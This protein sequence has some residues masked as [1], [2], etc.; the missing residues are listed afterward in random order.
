MARRAADDRALLYRGRA[1]GRHPAG[2]A[3]LGGRSG[4]VPG[5]EPSEDAISCGPAAG[6]RPAASGGAGPWP[7]SRPC[8]VIA[9]LAGAGI[10]VKR[11]RATAAQQRTANVGAAAWPRRARPWTP[12]IRSRPRS[13][14]GP[15]G[16]SSPTAQA[17]YSLLQSL[18]QPVRGVLTA[19]SG[20]V[21]ALAY[22]PDG[23][24]L[25][26][27]YSGGAIR[28]WDLA[29]HRAIS[30]TTWGAAPL[31]LAF[32]SGGKV[33]E[34]AGRRRRRHLEPGR[35]GPDH[36]AAAG[37]PGA[38][39]RG[40]VQ[41]G[42]QA[43]L[44]TGG[45]DGNVRLWNAATGQEIGPPMSSD[46]KPV[47]GRGVQPQR[48]AGGRGQRG[49]KRPAVEHGQP[50]GGRTGPGPATARRL[51]RWRSAPTASCWPPAARTAPP[52]SGT[53]RRGA[54]SARPWRPATR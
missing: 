51:T 36:R 54:R 47:D 27:G 13:W 18:A 33:L 50:A 29:S 7:G 35:P 4:P 48:H 21:T 22:S 19:P 16:G 41:P 53:S 40:G 24:T 8:V 46:A 3:R 26:A 28:L 34:V 44:A 25:A 2:R 14:P 17:R 9:A 6:P 32:T 12:P 20:V 49:R 15:P 23:G 43:S 39:Q 38:R 37:Q 5:A 10:A 11:A 45:A 1:A 31:A 52:G 30:A 42:R